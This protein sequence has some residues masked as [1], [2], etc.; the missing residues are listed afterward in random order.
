MAQGTSDVA[1]G[2]KELLNQGL[3]EARMARQEANNK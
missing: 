2:R 3:V 1:K